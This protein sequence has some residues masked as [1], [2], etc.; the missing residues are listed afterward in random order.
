VNDFTLCAHD[1]LKLAL[2]MGALF[3]TI[4]AWTGVMVL[5]AKHGGA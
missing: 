3:G 5:V 4:A 1:V 2:V